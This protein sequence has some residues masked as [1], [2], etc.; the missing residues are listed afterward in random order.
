MFLLVI[1]VVLLP[2]QHLCFDMQ[3]FYWAYAA[4]PVHILYG[5]SLYP[6][7]LGIEIRVYWSFCRKFNSKQFL[8][9]VFFDTIGIFCSVQRWSEITC[10]LNLYIL[11]I[12]FTFGSPSVRLIW[13]ECDVKRVALYCRYSIPFCCNLSGV[14]GTREGSLVRRTR[15]RGQSLHITISF[16][17]CI[18][19]GIPV[20]YLRFTSSPINIKLMGRFQS[21][22][23]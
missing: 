18:I 8:F 16:R 6:P 3:K 1:R 5:R 19:C 23:H 13:S 2:T 17:D 21:Q 4:S 15:M 12:M 14:G 9:E 10:P 7:L 11:S 20:C 22:C